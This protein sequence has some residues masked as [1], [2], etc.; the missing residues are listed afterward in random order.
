ME[1]AALRYRYPQGPLALDGVSAHIGHGES[2]ALVGANGAG[3]STLLQHLVGLL[4]PEQG[5]LTIG[6][7]P[8]VPGT[9]GHIR[10][11]V[12]L[13]FQDPDD[14]LFMPTVLEDVAFGPLNQGIPA[15]QSRALAL[16]C[17]EQVDAVGLGERAPYQ[18]SGGEKRRVALA[19]VLANDPAILVL[20]EPSAGLDPYS[21]RQ[22]I[23]LLDGFEHTKLIASHDLELVLELCPRTIMLDSGKVAADGPTAQ[24][25]GDEALLRRCRLERPASL[26]PC[27]TCGVV[28]HP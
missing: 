12:G 4:L 22:L 26:S 27:P 9:L 1:I 15:E 20:D 3:K 19:A 6:E 11:S 14:Q 7:T 21:R 24:L 10:R 28:R 13:L 18:L 17:L 8:V 2:V 16:R 25:L 5:S 23:Q